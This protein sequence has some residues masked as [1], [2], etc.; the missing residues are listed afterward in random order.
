MSGAPA[1]PRADLPALTGIRG[2]AA[3]FVVAYHIRIG[4]APH[5]PEAAYF[6]LSK[7]YLAVDLF[8]MLSGFVLWLNYSAR[9]RRDG[10]D[11][12]PKYLARR[13]ARVWP[14]HL[15]ILALTMVYAALLASMGKL[16]PAH[17][18]WGEIP[19]H[20]LLVH[21]WGFT[22]ALT[23]NDPSWSISGEAAAYL[24]FPLIVLGVDWRRIPPA[25][26]IA[27]LLLLV[28]LLAGIMGWHGA[29]I[30]DR[31][32][33]RFGLL[34]AVT[35]F[36]MGTILCALW[37]RWCSTPR[38]AAALAGALVGGA[39]LLGLAM[40]APETLVVPL[41][42]AGSLLGVALT[43]DR[44]GNPLAARPIVYLGE[45]SYSTY[46]VH[47][48]LYILFKI[49]FVADPGN[50]PPALIGLFLLMTF[51]ASVVLYHGVERPAQRGLNRLFDRRLS[52]R[53]TLSAAE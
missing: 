37:R 51:A 3:W 27:A 15:F 25:L 12:V 41:F 7:G 30:L 6:A 48:L 5:L 33:P 45:I 42:L 38:P 28:V 46:L 43:A 49:A 11:A 47:F 10:F 19:L 35:E 26:A 31:D 44:A 22:G 24:L 53:P 52:R 16:N 1:E 40:D 50:V 32:I 8:F 14:L 4:A 2:L 21:N 34:R 29:D 18:P 23:W 17:Y 20:L 9:L 36:T 13:V 39:L